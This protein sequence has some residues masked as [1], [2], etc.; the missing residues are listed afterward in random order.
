MGF[1]AVIAAVGVGFSAYGASQQSSAA[2]SQANSQQEMIAQQ[3]RQEAL[4]RQA[5]ELDARRRQSE[6]LRQTQRA[7]AI[8]IATSNSQGG[9]LGSGIQGG[10]GQISGQSGVQSLGIGQNLEIGQ[11][12]F[13]SNA[14]E[15]QAKIGYAQAGSQMATGAVLSS[16]GGSLVSNAGTL[17]NIFGGFGRSSSTLQASSAYNP[18]RIGSLY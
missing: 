3:Q 14:L 8:A 9:L 13:A 2:K 16:L 15:S 18:S 1:S 7:R 6:I 4:R 12:I 11:N 5:M 10:F 17:N